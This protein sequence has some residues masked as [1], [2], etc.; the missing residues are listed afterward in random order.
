MAQKDDDAS[1]G[2]TKEHPKDL[3]TWREELKQHT[4]EFIEASP[5]EHVK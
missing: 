5:E 1:Q 3:K 4:K 2:S